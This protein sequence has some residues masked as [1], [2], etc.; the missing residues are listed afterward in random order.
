MSVCSGLVNQAR[1]LQPGQSDAAE[2][3]RRG[4]FGLPFK[5][6]ASLTIRI[7]TINHILYESIPKSC[8][9]LSQS[10]I[11]WLWKSWLALL[12][13]FAFAIEI[14]VYV[15]GS[16]NLLKETHERYLSRP[17]FFPRRARGAVW[18][19]EIQK[20]NLHL[21]KIYPQIIKWLQ[22]IW[23]ILQKNTFIFENIS[24]TYTG[25]NAII[26][27]F[28]RCSFSPSH[29]GNKKEKSW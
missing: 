26:N 13:A 25:C 8:V 7:H 11:W 4:S 19:L 28:C 16:R 3:I 29:A 27:Y 12:I 20:T 5:I 15:F 14:Y 1:D 21:R 6:W 24:P 17:N 9:S 10:W 22:C 18:N 23:Q 2:I